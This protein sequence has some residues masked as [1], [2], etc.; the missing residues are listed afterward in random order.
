MAFT[1]TSAIYTENMSKP[2][3]LQKVG[4]D[5]YDL[6]T[7]RRKDHFSKTA[8]DVFLKNDYVVSLANDHLSLEIKNPHRKKNNTLYTIVK[9]DSLIFVYDK[10][11][12]GIKIGL[13][14]DNILL[15]RNN[16]LLTKFEL[17]K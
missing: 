9:S 17:I 14:K 11:Y 6:N 3:I 4:R 13:D 2:R 15:Y 16:I 8:A 1:D 12:S 5:Q 7:R 10:R